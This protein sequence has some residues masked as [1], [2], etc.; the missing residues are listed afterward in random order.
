MSDFGL[1]EEVFQRY[2]NRG[3]SPALV[4]DDDGRWAVSDMGS[5]PIPGENGHT[6]N[7]C[8]A[9]WVTPE[10]WKPTIREAVALFVADNPLDD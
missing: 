1:V 4:S 10:Q 3:Y 5:Q 9:S 2:A 6:E 8:I 7:V